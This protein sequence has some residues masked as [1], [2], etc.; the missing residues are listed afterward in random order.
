MLRLNAFQLQQRD[1]QAQQLIT[2]L[3]STHLAL[4][5]LYKNLLVCRVL[6]G[7]GIV[8]VFSGFSRCKVLGQEIRGLMTVVSRAQFLLSPKRSSPFPVI[9]FWTLICIS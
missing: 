7:E 4:N 3:S 2:V 5:S 1:R 6:F 9:E 8:T